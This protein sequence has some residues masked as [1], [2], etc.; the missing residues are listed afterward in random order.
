MRR[1]FLVPGFAVLW[2]I[3]SPKAGIA[4]E[5]H[6]VA[7]AGNLDSVAALVKADPTLVRAL[8]R[9]QRTPLHWACRG[10]HFDLVRFLIDHGAY[11]NA[12]D[13]NGVTPLHS[14]ASRGHTDAAKLLIEHGAGL[15]VKG[16]LDLG[17]PI[18]YA[19]QGGHV[20]VVKLLMESGASLDARTIEERTPL[21]VAVAAGKSDVVN[22]LVDRL[23]TGDPDG[24]RA[25]DFD[26]TSALHL[27]CLNG[28]TACVRMLVLAGADVNVRNT[29]GQSPYDLAVDGNSPGLIELLTS[30][31][32]DQGAQQFPALKGLYL[33]ETPPGMTPKLFGKGIVS[34][35]RGVHSTVTFSPTLDEAVWNDRDTIC[36]MKMENGVWRAPRK[37]PFF[38]PNYGLDAPFYSFDGKRIYFLAG[39]LSPEGMSGDQ[40][41]WYISRT[42]DGW[43]EPILFDSVVNSVPIH[44]QI[45]MTNKGD[46]YTSNRAIF[47][48]RFDNGRHMTPEMLPAIINNVPDST[49]MAGTIGPLI[50]PQGD[51]LI[52]NRFN[53]RPSFAV[54]FLIS[55]RKPDGNWTQ[56]QDLGA[57]LGGSG[58]AARLSPDG[59]YLF[60]MSDR[61]G[62]ARERSIYWVDAKIIDELKHR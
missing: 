8:D 19:A 37:I 46:V 51:Y 62:S 50:S 15:D 42:S 57:K 27:A 7:Q 32:A 30:S 9:L 59:K 24:L 39:Q 34:T 1:P 35:S 31:G 47:C 52:F 6:D 26:G 41:I 60:F 48:S 36:V 21:L 29:I 23:K 2:L 20:E 10:V 38:R 56:P 4:A 43:S 54:D 40:D 11:V 14:V 12:V 16:K 28:D 58:M 53:P 13:V 49:Q 33:G 45:S 22:V 61:P 3:V 55:F 5:I 44:W 17:T 18:H 25:K